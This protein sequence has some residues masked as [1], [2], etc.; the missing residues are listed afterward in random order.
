M[1]RK[2]YFLSREA[3]PGF[4][5]GLARDRD[6]YYPRQ[7]NGDWRFVK[8]D[9]E[10]EDA[11][12]ISPYRA[13]ESLKNFLFPERVVVASLPAK[14]DKYGSGRERIVFGLKACDLACLPVLDYIFREGECPD[15]FYREMREKT[16]LVSGDCTGFKEV[17]FCPVVGREPFPREGFDLNLTELADGY[18][19]EAG[20]ERGEKLIGEGGDAF[21]PATPEELQ[22]RDRH[23]AKVLS[24]L[25]KQLSE[26][27]QIEKAPSADEVRTKSADPLWQEE[28]L[29]C[30]ECGACNLVCPTCHC[31]ILEEVGAAGGSLKYR[32]WD[33]CQY[34]GF[35]RVAGGANPRPKRS[36][37]LS[38]RF[39]KKFQFFPDVAGVI[40][41][42]GCGRCFEACMGK[43]DIRKILARL[44]SS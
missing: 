9:G 43:I 1:E 39:S 34:P 35:P 38:N 24:D 44:K 17:C 7:I 32:N 20:S 27:G 31:F 16:I 22:D 21:R 40:A 33:S 14:I 6:L 3:F 2:R 42:T 23:R 28:A 25:K 13:V 29:P 11:A 15:P 8:W 36:E 37:R 41:C 19:V 30:V 26:Q 12:A 4:L 10:S 5:T 18:L